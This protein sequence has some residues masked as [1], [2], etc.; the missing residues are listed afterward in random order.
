MRDLWDGNKIEERGFFKGC[1]IAIKRG[2]KIIIFNGFNDFKSN[3]KLL[4]S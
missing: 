2:V 3:F 4:N 1:E